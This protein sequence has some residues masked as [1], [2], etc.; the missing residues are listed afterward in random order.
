MWQVACCFTYLLL[1]T[2]M[3]C[4]FRQWSQWVFAQKCCTWN[5]K[6]L[7][8]KTLKNCTIISHCASDS[9]GLRS[10]APSGALP[11]DPHW[12]LPSYRPSLF[13]QFLIHPLWTPSV[14]QTHPNYHPLKALGIL[15]VMLLARYMPFWRK[16]HQCCRN[17]CQNKPCFN[18][19]MHQILCRLQIRPRPSWGS[20][21]RSPV[22]SLD[23]R[24]PTSKG[25]G[26]KE[27]KREQDGDRKGEGREKGC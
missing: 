19:K 23:L 11:L 17:C 15:S 10:P 13:T 2:V 25:R 22:P 12:G 21:Q 1:F 3:H 26:R 27:R 4:W 6:I 7:Y 18:V 24:G 20:L 9:G 5:P 16:R 14:D 8:R